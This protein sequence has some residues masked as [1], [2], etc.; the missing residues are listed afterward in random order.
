MLISIKAA[1]DVLIAIAAT[2][3]LIGPMVIATLLLM[4]GI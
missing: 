1:L 4:F 2:A 3:V